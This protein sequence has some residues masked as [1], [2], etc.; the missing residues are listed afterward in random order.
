MSSSTIEMAIF[1][2]LSIPSAIR[3]ELLKQ[4]F[5]YSLVII[6]PISISSVY[7][8]EMLDA[9]EKKIFFAS[10]TIIFGLIIPAI[11]VK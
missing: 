9:F 7:L 2:L 3:L 10:L 6:A 5:I 8:L 4:A 1:L 11:I